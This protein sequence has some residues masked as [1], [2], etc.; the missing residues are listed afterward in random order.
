MK[1]LIQFSGG[2]DSTA[3]LIWAVKESGFKKENIIAVFCDTG[4]ENEKTYKYIF[5]IKEKLGI[6]LLILKSKKYNDFFDLAEK[7]KRF[8]SLR[9]RFC[10]EELK[11]KPMIDYIL[12]FVKEHILIVQGIRADESETRSKMAMDCQY[13]KY[14][15][16][17]LNE[18]KLKKQTNNLNLFYEEKTEQPKFHTYR[19][20]DVFAWK[21]LYSDDIIRPFFYK[22]DK[23]TINYILE[24]GFSLNPLYYEGFGRVGCFPCVL[25]QKREV[26]LIIENYP[27]IA[28][29][30]INQEE[31]KNACFFP[32]DYIPAR[33]CSNKSINKK[34]QL[35]SYPTFSDVIKYVQD[36]KN[37]LHLEEKTEKTACMSIYN[38]CE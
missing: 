7:K 25:A 10:T 22:S 8:P 23:E 2:K 3:S 6:K 36:N 38:I 21:K 32:P 9:A 28:Q 29:K 33:F 34:G 1:C 14:Y 13:F 37:Q 5:E 19:K 12:D 20:K 26:K 30:I 11:A 17:P 31:K 18:E 15:F 35:V 27:D 4:F 16:K 24:N